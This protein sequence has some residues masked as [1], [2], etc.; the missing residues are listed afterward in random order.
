MIGYW[1]YLPLKCLFSLIDW[2]FCRL[3]PNIIRLMSMIAYELQQANVCF[4]T[5]NEKYGSFKIEK[6]GLLVGLKLK[7]RCRDGVRSKRGCRPKSSV[8]ITNN[9][10]KVMFPK[11]RRSSAFT[12]L[13]NSPSRW[14][15]EF[16]QKF[17]RIWIN[18]NY[19]INLIQIKFFFYVYLCSFSWA[20]SSVFKLKLK[21]NSAQFTIH[22]RHSLVSK[23][24]EMRLWHTEDY[25]KLSGVND[26][27]E[28]CANVY[29]IINGKNFPCANVYAI[30][31]GKIT[32]MVRFFQRRLFFIYLLISLSFFITN[33][34]NL[35]WIAFS[36]RIWKFK[37]LYYTIGW[38]L[39]ESNVCFRS[40]SNGFGSFSILEDGRLVAVKLVHRTGYIKC[41]KNNVGAR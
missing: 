2:N 7:H 23:A 3:I 28:A 26:S 11:I 34:W 24:Q 10:N 30:I 9:K 8:L 17:K 1:N 37:Y 13:L 6:D 27:A 20:G 21:L 35:Q 29:A 19:H 36:F 41:K 15:E 25:R 4:G 31:N 32:T 33:I 39:Q 38:S 18:P 22:C 40:K 16:Y 14:D 12:L 5:K